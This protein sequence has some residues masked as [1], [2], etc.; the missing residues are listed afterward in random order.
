M[1]IFALHF[2]ANAVAEFHEL[3]AG[4]AIQ[5]GFN[6]P[7]FRNAAITFGPLRLAI[8]VDAFV[9]DRATAHNGARAHVARFAHVRNELSEV[10]GHFGTRFT[11]A[12]LATIPS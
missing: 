2:N 4:F 9:A 7:L 6:S 5:N 8:D 12:H 10:E 1:P 3:G 11:H